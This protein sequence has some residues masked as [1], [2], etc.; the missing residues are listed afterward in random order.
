MNILSII[1]FFVVAVLFCFLLK[2]KWGG[3]QAKENEA[4]LLLGFKYLLSTS[5]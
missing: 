5:S 1:G 4:W 2:Y 3:I